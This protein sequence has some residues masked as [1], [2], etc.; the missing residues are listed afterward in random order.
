M[1]FSHYCQKQPAAVLTILPDPSL[2]AMESEE[3]INRVQRGLSW[4]EEL[5]GSRNL[6]AHYGG[7]CL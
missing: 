1:A 2:T 3:W 7:L 6:R 4:I 5:T